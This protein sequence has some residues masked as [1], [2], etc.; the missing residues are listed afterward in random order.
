MS[1]AME[2]PSSGKPLF[3]DTS[4][5]K[6]NTPKEE[7]K[8]VMM[9]VCRGL[10]YLHSRSC[11]HRNIATRNC[12]Y[13]K[14]KT[15]CGRGVGQGGAGEDLGLQSREAEKANSEATDHSANHRRASSCCGPR[16][17]T[18]PDTGELKIC[19][20]DPSRGRGS[21]AGHA[22]LPVDICGGGGQKTVRD[23]REVTEED[24]RETRGESTF[25]EKRTRRR[26]GSLT[27]MSHLR[28]FPKYFHGFPFQKFKGK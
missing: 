18:P 26:Q 14:E 13:T 12:L 27:Q 10:E 17:C 20:E 21:G 24:I 9:G 11:I 1:R 16:P 4:L 28:Y 25:A 2:R 7:K 3:I 23:L 5:C 6:R 15:V 22:H 8:K 19:S